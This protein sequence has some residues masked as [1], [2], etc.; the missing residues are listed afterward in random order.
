MRKEIKTKD[1][2]KTASE[3]KNRIRA[4]AAYVSTCIMMVPVHVYAAD[5]TSNTSNDGSAQWNTV[6]DFLLTWIPRLGGLMLFGGAIEYAI[7]YQSENAGQKTN[8]VRIMVAGGM[9]IGIPFAISSL[10]KI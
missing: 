6:M 3:M 9:L 7:A 5:G 1:Y 8:A 4:Y 10:I 2:K